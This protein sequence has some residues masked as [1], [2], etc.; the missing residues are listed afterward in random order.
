MLGF[1]LIHESKKPCLFIYLSNGFAIRYVFQT[2]IFKTLLNS[3]I[4]IVI[5]SPEADDPGFRSRFSQENVSIEPLK[6]EEYRSLNR[7]WL[8]YQFKEIRSFV[9]NGDFSTRTVDDFRR[10]H[11]A[12][13]KWNREGGWKGIV[14]GSLWNFLCGCLKRS[15]SLRQLFL[16]VETALFT[17]RLHR[18]LF[19]KHQPNLVLIASVGTFDFDHFVAREARSE[20]VPVCS[21]VM[22]WDNTS[23]M[24]MPGAPVD[25]VIAWSETMK[26]ELIE[27]NDIDPSKITVGGVACY[28]HYYDPSV[29]V[30]KNELFKSLGLDPSKK[31]L[32][33]AT[34]SPKRFPWAGDIVQILA[35]KIISGEIEQSP[36]VLVRLHPIY[37][38]KENG[39]L[40]FK[41]LIKQ[42]EDVC[43]RYPFVKLNYPSVLDKK[44]DFELDRSE[45]QLVASLLKHCD[46]LLHLF[47]TMVLEA[48]LFDLP[49]IN[50]CLRDLCKAELG[51]TRQ[52]IMI[53]YHQDHNQRPIQAGGVKTVFTE[54]EI[55]PAI[56][57]YLND[58]ALDEA[59]RKRIVSQEMGPYPGYA[60]RRIGETILGL[61]SAN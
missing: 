52:D 31:T 9:L 59:G 11:M 61:L 8:Q 50:L 25:H 39:T 40:I 49:S 21:I 32:L 14:K 3:K 16:I 58:R 46:V 19:L 54:S 24:G 27:L 56:N 20:K 18:S 55:A 23:G 5:L 26:K 13:R 41:D 12:R 38:R 57:A 33:F 37:F 45:L 6:I 43:Q 60:G 36:Q 35:E 4:K 48:S 34:K 30:S 1:T 42:L 53:D 29:V 17:P 7:H 15:K 22:S 10:I 47:S 28:D 44:S 2:E 51:K